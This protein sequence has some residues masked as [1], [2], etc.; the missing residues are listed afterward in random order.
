MAFVIS[1]LFGSLAYQALGADPIADK[2]Q[3][4]P[5]CAPLPSNMF[6]G[7]LPVTQQKA[8]H[9]VFVE[10]MDKP[11]TDPILLWFNG[12]PGCSSLS[13]FFVQHGPYI[14]D[15]GETV[16]K[17]NPYPWSIRA[18]VLDIDSP[19]GVG[20]SIGNTTDDLLSNDIS[21]ADDAFIALQ[22]FYKAYPQYRKNDLWIT[23]ESYAGIYSPYLAWKI[24]Q[25]N[26]E[27]EMNNWN[28]TYNLKGFI[29]GNGMTDMYIDT[30]NVLLESVA[31]WNLIPVSLWKQMDALECTYFWG[32]VSELQHNAEGCDELYKKGMGLIKDLDIYDLFR[33]QYNANTNTQSTLKP[34][35]SQR[36]FL[37]S[38]HPL[39]QAKDSYIS[40]DME[41]YVNR[42]DVRQALNIPS[43]VQP[44]QDCNDDLYNT[45]S[46]LREGSIWIYNILLGY[47][48]R[49]R[50]MHYSGDTDGAVATL[51]TRRWIT[52]QEGWNVTNEWR[53]WT[54]DGDVCH[55][56]WSGT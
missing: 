49:Y 48:K 34:S 27:Q 28:D 23:G 40:Y 24:H 25:W 20:Y 35:V 39:K 36:R 52:Q 17:P 9:Y 31:N 29:V 16:I 54:T 11:A 38:R 50:I 55:H 26:L 15:D 6:S 46:V 10:S 41:S 5:D 42:P 47:E 33:T 32:K 12:G 13:D 18:N 19:A 2:V 4:L 1:I 7:Y 45:Y 30:D 53:P 44:F 14:F 56:S 43:F 3:S 22:N 51:G 37:H 8:L 21:T